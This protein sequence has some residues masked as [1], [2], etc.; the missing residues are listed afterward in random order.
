MLPYIGKYYSHEYVRTQILRQ[1][2]DEIVEMDKEISKEKSVAQ[3]KIVLDA[4]G[5][6]IEPDVPPTF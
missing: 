5:M 6:P 3:Y 2:D 4:D 1:T